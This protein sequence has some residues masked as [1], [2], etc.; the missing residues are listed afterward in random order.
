MNLRATIS[1]HESV[2][3]AQIAAIEKL[4]KRELNY[5]IVLNV[6]GVHSHIEFDANEEE[7]D[8]IQNDLGYKTRLK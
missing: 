7:L 6:K 3:H 1:T 8:L 4:L 5:Q 2:I